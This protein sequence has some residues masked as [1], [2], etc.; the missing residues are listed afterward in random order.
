M[1][2]LTVA[3]CVFTHNG[4]TQLLRTES[5]YLLSDTLQKSH[6]AH[7]TVM[8]TAKARRH[9]AS[10]MTFNTPHPHKYLMNKAKVSTRINICISMKYLRI[11]ENKGHSL[12]HWTHLA[13]E[14]AQVVLWFKWELSPK[15]HMFGHVVCSWQCCLGEVLE[16]L[17]SGELLEEVCHGAGS[18]L[19]L[20]VC[21]WYVIGQLSGPAALLSHPL[22]TRPRELK[23]E[24]N[25]HL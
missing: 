4:G 22:N 10:P 11:M 21:D 24:I 16:L 15:A 9:P 12:T 20:P 25:F 19:L 8:Q 13:G 3:A 18:I 14:V 17:G 7:G 23:T 1:Y 2:R 6:R 5:Q